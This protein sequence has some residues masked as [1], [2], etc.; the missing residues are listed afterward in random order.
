M[1]KERVSLKDWQRGGFVPVS[2]RENF[3]YGGNQAWL[4][5]EGVSK[6]YANRA[7]GVTAAANTLCYMSAHIDGMRSLYAAPDL[8][9]AS[10]SAYQR[11]LYRYIRPFA[12]GVPTLESAA[13][14][15]QAFAHGRGVKIAPMRLVRPKTKGEAIDFIARALNRERPVMLLTW[16]DKVQKDLSYH[17]VTVASLS[18]KEGQEAFT[19]STW[20]TMRTYS[21]DKWLMGK[22]LYRGLLYFE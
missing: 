7:C 13:A 2:E 3:Y 1:P 20:S 18:L 22:S 15:I 8:S 12:W 14:G 5:R 17:W 9:L 6:F 10:F 11:E 19:A 16:N 21:L 4:T